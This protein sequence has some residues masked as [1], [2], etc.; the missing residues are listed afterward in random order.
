[1]S[2]LCLRA[3]QAPIG[4]SRNL[5]ALEGTNESGLWPGAIELD[6]FQVMAR[7][8]QIIRLTDAAGTKQHYRQ[9]GMAL[10]KGMAAF[11]YEH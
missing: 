3:H 4:L 10:F 2:Q 9:A 5:F 1:M 7:K 11:E 8:E 6:W